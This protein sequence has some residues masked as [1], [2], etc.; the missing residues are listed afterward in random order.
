MKYSV[1]EQ[2]SKT[3]LSSFRS[4]TRYSKMIRSSLGVQF[5][6]VIIAEHMHVNYFKAS[7]L[8]HPKSAHRVIKRCKNNNYC[9]HCISFY[10]KMYVC[11]NIDNVC[12]SIFCQPNCLINVLGFIKTT[13]TT[14]HFT[15]N[16]NASKIYMKRICTYIYIY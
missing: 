6:N 13:R 4:I 15:L 16:T 2:S 3:M 9:M 8:C 5:I 11:K 1:R 10:M 14:V 7:V 12:M